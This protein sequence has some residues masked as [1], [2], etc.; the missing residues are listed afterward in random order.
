MAIIGPPLPCWHEAFA[1]NRKPARTAA[2][3]RLVSS[4]S[5]DGRGRIGFYLL[6]E[7]TAPSAPTG[8]AR[9]EPV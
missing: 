2:L 3:N 9:T 7:E 5:I 1:P 8:L 4:S 6:A